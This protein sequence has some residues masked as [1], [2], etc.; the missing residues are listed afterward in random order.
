M[1]SAI[2]GSRKPEEK[3]YVTVLDRLKENAEEVLFLDDI[4]SNLKAAQKL[5]FRTLKV[6]ALKVF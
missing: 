2:E 4:G 3:I 5:G 1:E 6:K